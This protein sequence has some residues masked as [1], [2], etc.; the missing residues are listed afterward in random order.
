MNEFM[1]WEFLGTF[2]GAALATGILTQA[3]KGLLKRVPTQVVSYAIALVVLVGATAALRGASGWADW[4][5]LPLN[6]VAVSL[7]ANGAYA[8]VARVRG[9]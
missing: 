9:V 1:T 2:A 4:A 7:A 5:I 3:V 8:A 6:A